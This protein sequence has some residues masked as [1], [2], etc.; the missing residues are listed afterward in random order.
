MLTIARS[1]DDPVPALDATHRAVKKNRPALPCGRPA[2]S[3]PGERRLTA[4]SERVA[5]VN[6]DRARLVGEVADARVATTLVVERQ[7]RGLIPDVV[8][9]RRQLPAIG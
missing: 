6:S 4:S 1:P 7:T 3:I 9:V 2:S 5:A 8:E